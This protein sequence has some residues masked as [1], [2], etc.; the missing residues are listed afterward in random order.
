MVPLILR[1][2]PSAWI[3][4]LATL[5]LFFFLTWTQV[6][7]LAQQG[8]LPTQL[9]LQSHLIIKWPK[10]AHTSISMEGKGSEKGSVLTGLGRGDGSSNVPAAFL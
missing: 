8:L 2:P 5:N 7:M 6:L 1:T 3:S 9:S 10:K 4:H